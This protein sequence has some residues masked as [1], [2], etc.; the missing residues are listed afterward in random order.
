MDTT[1]AK[2]TLFRGITYRSRLEAQY[3]SLFDLL[4]CAYTY[5]DEYIEDL[6]SPK[7]WL[8]DFTLF[9]DDEMANLYGGLFVEVK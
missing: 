8:P 3:S 6:G 5:E 9:P 1:A 2:P 7:G 4:G